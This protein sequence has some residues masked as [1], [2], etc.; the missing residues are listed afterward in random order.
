MEN[1]V[2]SNIVDFIFSFKFVV[3]IVLY[4]FWVEIQAIREST[5]YTR[6]RI[7]RR[8]KQHDDKPREEE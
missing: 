3:C 4:I 6:A 8:W 7:M 5:S 2:L 1:E